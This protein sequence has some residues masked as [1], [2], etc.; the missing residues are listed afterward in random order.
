MARHSL[1]DEQ[2]EMIVDLFPARKPTG[3]ARMD[4]RVAFGHPLDPPHRCA[5]ARPAER[6]GKLAD[7][8]WPLRSVERRRDLGC[9][10]GSP[11]G[12]SHRRRSDWPFLVVCRRQRCPGSALRGRRQ[13]GSRGAA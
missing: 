8:L 4:H 3:R 7:G 2:W 13:R 10:A 12:R 9:G 6:E 1:T 5:M 11:E